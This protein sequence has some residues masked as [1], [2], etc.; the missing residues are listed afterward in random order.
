MPMGPL[1]RFFALSLSLSVTSLFLFLLIIYHHLP[2]SLTAVAT[3]RGSLTPRALG[4]PNP[5]AALVAGEGACEDPLKQ[6]LR[7]FDR[8]AAHLPPEHRLRVSLL[9]TVSPMGRIQPASQL[10][11][12]LS[13]TRKR[14]P[15]AGI[16]GPV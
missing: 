3:A 15:L 8:S 12:S 6:I 4:N 11:L 16:E 2:P 5:S 14:A 9:R 10:P 13:P 1:S 7:P